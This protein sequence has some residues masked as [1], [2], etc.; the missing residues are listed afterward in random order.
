MDLLQ[1]RMEG[2]L[3]EKSSQYAVLI[4]DSAKKMERLINDLLSLAR[5]GR[6]KMQKNEVNI[7][8]MVKEIIEQ[9][10]NETSG[11]DI[12]WKLGELPVVYGDPSMLKLVL[13][14]LISNAVKFT[15]PRPRAEIEIGCR[16]DGSEDVCFIKD[17]GVGFKM[18]DVDRLFGVFQ[19][20]HPADEFE[21]AG[22]GL[23]NVRRIMSLHGGRTWAE[24]LVG[25]GATFCFA[26]PRPIE[27]IK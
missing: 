19:R 20:L 23:A 15:S 12:E 21:G 26:L 16:K 25:Q 8:N 9:I 4:S 2:Q 1:K 18:D 11:R 22:I 17:N 13:F 5:L 7:C 6:E 14:N 10:S 24:G 3:D 27:H